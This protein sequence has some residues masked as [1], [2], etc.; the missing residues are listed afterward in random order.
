MMTGYGW[1]GGF[2]GFGMI[3]MWLFWIGVIALS[4]WLIASL[5][6]KSNQMDKRADTSTALDILQR[7]Y[8]NGE[9]SAEQYTEMRHDIES[10][11]SF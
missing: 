9:V 7:R 5:F 11:L 4:I 2:G 1:F 8:A 10:T 3:F 6:S